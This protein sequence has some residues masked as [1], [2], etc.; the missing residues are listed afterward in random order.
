MHGT[1]GELTLRSQPDA[2]G[3]RISVGDTGVGLPVEAGDR[4][5][6]AFVTTKPQGS[7]LGLAI[8]RSIIEAHGGK[9]WADGGA[10]HG[11]TFHFT[12]PGSAT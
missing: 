5:F 12:L 7:G 11:A 2:E 4:I 10:P 8:S 3:L 1:G 6:D 9:L